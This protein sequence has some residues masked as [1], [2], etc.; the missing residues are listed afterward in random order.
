LLTSSIKNNPAY[1]GVKRGD[2][3]AYI[4]RLLD[5]ELGLDLAIARLQKNVQDS[6]HQYEAGIVDKTDYKRATISLN[7]TIAPRKQVNDLVKAKSTIT[8]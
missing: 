7:N 3:Y 2:F 4:S 6:Y 5:L 1:I 8:I